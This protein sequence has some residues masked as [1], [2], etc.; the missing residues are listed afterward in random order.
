M[1][2]RVKLEALFS[3]VTERN[4]NQTTGYRRNQTSVVK[5][6][7]NTNTLLMCIVT[8]SRSSPQLI[9]PRGRGRTAAGSR[10][11]GG[12]NYLFPGYHSGVR[13]FYVPSYDEYG[14]KRTSE[15]ARIFYHFILNAGVFY[16]L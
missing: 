6:A 14:K 4:Y 9:R 15:V 10:A 11:A 3:H 5:D 8:Y 13:P 1:F 12:R 16:V 2:G 7:F